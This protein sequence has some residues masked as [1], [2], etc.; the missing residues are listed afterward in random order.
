LNSPE[1]ATELVQHL[2][3]TQAAASLGSTVG[4]GA[5]LAGLYLGYAALGRWF[6][7]LMQSA[8]RHQP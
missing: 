7:R 2:Y 8:V 3:Q 5:I 1:P 6:Q 4:A